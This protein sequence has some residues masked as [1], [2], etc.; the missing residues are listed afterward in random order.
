MAKSF[1]A[2]VHP[3]GR[4][5][6]PHHVTH[7]ASGA[8]WQWHGML[9][10]RALPGDITEAELARIY[11]GSLWHYE[12]PDDYSV[13]GVPRYRLTER[14]TAQVARDLD[15]LALDVHVSHN[16]AC[17][18]G[19][20]VLLD[21]VTNAGGLTGVQYF[22]VGTGEG[23][24]ASTDTTLFTEFFRKA[25]TST[26]ISGGTANILTTFNSGEGNTT[27][28]EAGLFG[29]GATGTANSGQLFNHA[30]YVY[31]KTSAVVLSNQISITLA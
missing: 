10:A 8:R 5:I 22:A 3:Q 16:V 21:L 24:P 12:H 27:Y 25:P 7:A 15:R 2:M 28:T 29:D 20:T 26:S 23:T 4:P 19:R 6:P 30:P 11:A 9:T 13:N 31:V 1:F 14:E 18:A 17:N